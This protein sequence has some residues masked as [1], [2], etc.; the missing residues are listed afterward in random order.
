MKALF[1]YPRFH[2]NSIGWIHA[3]KSNHVQVSMLVIYKGATEDHTHIMP[4]VMKPGF[5]T[6]LNLKF[7]PENGRN[8]DYYRK[9]FSPSILFIVSYLIKNKPDIAICR[10]RSITSLIVCIACKCL[11]IE[12]VIYDQRPWAKQE[13]PIKKV[14]TKVF[15]SK[16]HMT[17]LS[18]NKPSDLDEN[19][20]YIPFSIENASDLYSKSYMRHGKINF[21]TIGK[22][23]PRKNLLL[24]IEAAKA[25]SSQFHITLKIIGEV[26]TQEHQ[27]YYNQVYQK[28]SDARLENVI[29]L[30]KNIPHA[31]MNSFWMESDVFL[32]VSVR[33]CASVSQIEAMSKGLPVII[34]SDN[35]TAEYVADN[36]SG[37]IIDVHSPYVIENNYDLF[38]AMKFYCKNTEEI[39]KQGNY[40]MKMANQIHGEEAAINNFNNMFHSINSF[41]H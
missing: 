17:P 8:F 20:F 22:Y 32:I 13:G 25:L 28:I 5:L 26:S 38:T 11:K 23:E 10:D 30:Y 3:L 16:Y 34:G 36:L 31:K 6:W 4:E 24:L 1:V 29:T 37:K 41:P 12:K 33:E 35:G 39:Q 18:K 9:I 27:A 19:T 15:F 21:L 2:T 40:A 7:S 14:I